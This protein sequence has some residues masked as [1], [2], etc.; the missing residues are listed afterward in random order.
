VLRRDRG[1][2]LEVS[3]RYIKEHLCFNRCSWIIFAGEFHVAFSQSLELL[4]LARLP[5]LQSSSCYIWPQVCKVGVFT[6]TN[7]K[8]G[9]DDENGIA[10]KKN[11]DD[12]NGVGSIQTL[13]LL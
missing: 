6:I 10:D 12:E 2:K 4:V 5:S 9:V 8:N 13:Q 11:A 3:G 7:D 1:E